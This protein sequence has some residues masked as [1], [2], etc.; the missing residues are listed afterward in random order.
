MAKVKSK[1]V[2]QNCGYESAGYLG[3]CPEKFTYD[4]RE[5]TPK[6][7]AESLGLDFDDYIS[8]TS[9]T[10]HPFYSS[11]IIEA[12]YKWRPRP[13]YNVPLD[14]MMNIIDI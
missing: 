13:S 12:P 14:S 10:H 11:F 8:I 5:Y 6:S 9:F 3:K 2:C 1:W 4:G 7:F